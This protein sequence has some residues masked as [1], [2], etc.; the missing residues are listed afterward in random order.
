MEE[1]LSDAL[2]DQFDFIQ[3]DRARGSRAVGTALDPSAGAGASWLRIMAA[4]SSQVRPAPLSPK[5]SPGFKTA[6]VRVL[7]HSGSSSGSAACCS[8]VL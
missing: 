8:Q 4:R 1:S 5:L 3:I 2:L 6:F 7:G